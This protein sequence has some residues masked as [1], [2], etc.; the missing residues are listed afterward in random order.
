LLRTL[1]V[2]HKRPSTQALGSMKKARQEPRV[3]RYLIY[4]LIDPRNSCLRYVGK[5]HKRREIRL[6]EHV[7]DAAEGG[8]R[9]VHEW[10]RD[11]LAS[12]CKPEI[13]VL[14]RVSAN[15][16]WASAEKLAIARWREWP[17]QQLPYSH[18]PQTPKSHEVEIHCVRLLNV[19]SGG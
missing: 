15:S 3:G 11:L 7:E 13:F 12:G 16:D 10:I 14:A 19:R 2:L 17:E 5:T 4:G 8:S 18:P 6:A 9:P 1:R